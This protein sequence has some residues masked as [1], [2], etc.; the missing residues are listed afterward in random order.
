MHIWLQ[1]SEPNFRPLRSDGVFVIDFLLSFSTPA[2]ISATLSG[3]IV[4]EAF[5]EEIHVTI[6]VI[7]PSL[8]YIFIASISYRKEAPKTTQRPK[9]GSEFW[10]HLNVS[11]ANPG[12]S[13]RSL[14]TSAVT[15]M[16]SMFD[17]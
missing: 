7:S 16:S 15:D 13:I 1:D 3:P 17:G 9:F 8:F 11:K 6:G 2:S 4:S 5:H 12:T 10:S 14:N